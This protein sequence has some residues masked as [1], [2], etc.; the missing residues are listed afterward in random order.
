MV[1]VKLS[2]G[3]RTWFRGAVSA[4]VGGG[5]SSVAAIVI[6]PRSFNFSSLGGLSHVL[7]L[8]AVAAFFSVMHYLA[9]SP[10]PPA[11]QTIQ[12]DV[13]RKDADGNV[14]SQTSTQTTVKT[15]QPG[16]PIL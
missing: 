14:L 2:Q 10:L 4:G 1:K 5:A 12:Q 3:T 11:E 6:D 7:S 16:P 9:Q 8:F 15:S 13:L